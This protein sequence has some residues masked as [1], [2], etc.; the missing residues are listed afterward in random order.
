MRHDLYWG[1]FAIFSGMLFSL[2]TTIL[3]RPM[4]ALD[5]WLHGEKHRHLREGTIGWKV[6]R[7]GR[8]AMA[9]WWYRP[10]HFLLGL[11]M[12]FIAFKLLG[13]L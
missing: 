12:F 13:W 9:Q 6:Y 3:W 11:A 10:L 1:I 4:L 8:W 2:G 7:G 5:E